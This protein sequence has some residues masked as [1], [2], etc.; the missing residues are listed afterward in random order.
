MG[1]NR[2]R[3]TQSFLE[4]SK[5]NTE[6]T[7]QKISQLCSAAAENHLITALESHCSRR[8][9]D[10]F[11]NILADREFSFG[12]YLFTVSNSGPL[13]RHNALTDFPN[14]TFIFR[15]TD[16]EFDLTLN[17][18]V[19]LNMAKM[20]EHVTHQ[21]HFIRQHSWMHHSCRI[22]LVCDTHKHT[23]IESSTWATKV[24]SNGTSLWIHHH[25]RHSTAGHCLFVRRINYWRSAIEWRSAKEGRKLRREWSIYEPHGFWKGHTSL[26]S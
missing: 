15:D 6:N 22:I 9:I 10:D 21:G 26:L 25:R 13:F 5:K 12:C 14:F 17:F 24:V 11:S 19:D 20:I 8:R 7:L 18:E 23:L 3:S 2:V 4:L 1:R 16:P